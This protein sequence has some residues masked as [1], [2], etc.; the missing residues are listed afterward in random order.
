LAEASRAQWAIDDVVI[1]FNDSAE[2]GFDEDFSRSPRPD[3]WYMVMNA[4][5][6]VTCQS[7]DNALEFSKN[8]LLLTFTYLL[9]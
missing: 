9:L 2:T 5:P 8:G 6:R 7:R 4:V 1:A 3:V